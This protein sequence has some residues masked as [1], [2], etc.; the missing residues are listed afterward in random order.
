MGKT[1]NKKR[2]TCFAKHHCC[3]TSWI[4]MLRVLPPTIKKPLQPYYCSNVGGKM[5]NIA[6]QLVLQWCCKTVAKVCI[7]SWVPTSFPEAAILSVSTKDRLLPVATVKGSEGSKDE[8]DGGYHQRKKPCGR[9]SLS[10]PRFSRA[11]CRLAYMIKA[12]FYLS[13]LINLRSFCKDFGR[14]M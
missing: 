2:A 11:G 12:H 5:F 10:E 9:P 3:R 7:A 4:V 13:K 1:G 14:K 8:V 6:I